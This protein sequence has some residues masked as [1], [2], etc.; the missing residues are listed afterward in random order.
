MERYVAP[1]SEKIEIQIKDMVLSLSASLPWETA[2]KLDEFIKEFTTPETA[3]SYSHEETFEHF[4][5]MFV[6]VFSFDN[7]VSK[8][9]MVGLVKAL[10]VH[11]SIKLLLS[12]SNLCMEVATKTVNFTPAKPF[13]ELQD[14]KKKKAK[15]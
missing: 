9:D 8:E 5:E 15:K 2:R 4:V 10:G 13:K 3:Q 14:H 11:D 6:Q 1:L 7:Q 12:L